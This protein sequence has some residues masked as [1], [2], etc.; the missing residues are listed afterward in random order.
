MDNKLLETFKKHSEH[1][2]QLDTKDPEM[3]PFLA[4]VGKEA[5]FVRA[6]KQLDANI[7]NQKDQ[8]QLNKDRLK[9][10]E[11]AR[12]KQNS[13]DE[14]KLKLEESKVK[15]DEKLREKQLKIE[16]SKVQYEKDRLA[17]EKSRLKIEEQRQKDEAEIRKLTL[18]NETKRLENEN[19]KLQ[20]EKQRNDEDRAIRNKQLENE[21]VRYSNDSKANKRATLIGILGIAIPA[22]VTLFGKITSALLAYNAQK[23]DYE[24]F[25]IESNSSREHRNNLNK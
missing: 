23:H 18:S 11:K 3:K 22:A 5:E 12:E 1:F 19:T 16:E 13:L 14:K 7:S 8:I 25:K 15:S 21:Y 20:Y 6:E 10:D 17:I 24:D 9:A 2:N 4:V